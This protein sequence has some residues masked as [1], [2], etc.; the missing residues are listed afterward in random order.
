[1]YRY[2]DAYLPKGAE[3]S[4]NSSADRIF[5]P[6]MA[7]LMYYEN[8]TRRAAHPRCPPIEI[9]FKLKQTLRRIYKFNHLVS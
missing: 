6:L 7:H 3:H 1:M 8:V 4:A 2:M 9:F 5:D